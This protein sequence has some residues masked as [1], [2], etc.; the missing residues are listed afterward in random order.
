MC[1]ESIHCINFVILH[2]SQDCAHGIQSYQKA[3]WWKSLSKRTKIVTQQRVCALKSGW[4]PLLWK[5][6]LPKYVLFILCFPCSWKGCVFWPRWEGHP[7]VIE[8]FSTKGCTATALGL[9]VAFGKGSV[10]C[11]IPLTW[12][13]ICKEQIH[14]TSTILEHWDVLLLHKPQQDMHTCIENYK[15]LPCKIIRKMMLLALAL[16]QREGLMTNGFLVSK[17]TVVLRRWERW[18]PKI[19]FYQTSW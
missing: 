6:I 7:G 10:T 16:C 15:N 8:D 12:R 14:K 19:W 17:E 13:I 1:S 3:K 11:A 2:S 18:K 5:T 4:I 9:C